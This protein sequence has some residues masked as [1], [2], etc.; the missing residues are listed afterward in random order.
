MVFFIG[1][2]G[3]MAA[4]RKL[5]EGAKAQGYRVGGSPLR[6][7]AIPK[8]IDN[9]IVGTDV[10]PGYGSAARF[11]AQTVHDVGLDL[12]AM[13][14]FDDVAVIEVMGRHAGWLAAAAALARWDEA[15]PPHL[16]LLPEVPLDEVAFLEAVRRQHGRERMCIVVAAEGIRDRHGAF[17]AEKHKPLDCDLSGQKLFGL[18][19]GPCP[20]L[21]ALISERLGLRCR[22]MRPDV[23]QRSSSAMA[24]EVDRTLA[25]Q[26][27]E[28]AV[29]AALEG[30][31][32]VMIGLERRPTSWQSVPVPLDDVIG[33][34]RALPAQFVALTGFGVTDDF[35][36]YA[37]P[38]LG[39]WSPDAVRL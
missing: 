11:V 13:R 3:S 5:S 14:G 16:I 8:T 36:A 38:L 25:K 39:E 12:C 28:D 2:N 4:A 34:E 29:K 27:G 22:H 6:V 30:G 1:G 15:A 35:L 9:D 17:L 7:I 24:S 33:R 19:G 31:S 26:V 37:R 21:A 23:I 32:A 18:A 20:Y 10:C